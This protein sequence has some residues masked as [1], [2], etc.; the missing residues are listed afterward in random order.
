[1]VLWCIRY[2]LQLQYGL[3]VRRN[4]AAFVFP[5]IE[6]TFA[7]RMIYSTVAVGHKSTLLKI[8]KKWVLPDIVSPT[9]LFIHLLVRLISLFTPGIQL[10]FSSLQQIY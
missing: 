2:C 8:G 4:G 10:L 7:S 6:R 5:I 9:N 3:F 1:M